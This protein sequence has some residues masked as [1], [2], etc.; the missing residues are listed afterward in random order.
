MLLLLSGR[1]S[2]FLLL[3]ACCVIN[4]SLIEEKQGF[5]FSIPYCSNDVS[6]HQ[7][8]GLVVLSEMFV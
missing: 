1:D 2:A 4:I 3:A 5:W 6:I 7:S 8:N